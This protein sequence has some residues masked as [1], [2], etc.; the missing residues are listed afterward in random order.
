VRSIR[1]QRTTSAGN[2][3]E[4]AASSS[5]RASVGEELGGEGADAGEGAESVGKSGAVFQG[6]QGQLVAVEV[7]LAHV[8]RVS[9][10]ASV[11]D[12]GRPTAGDTDSLCEW[13]SGFSERQ[14]GL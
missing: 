6:V 14:S 7:L 12:S 2:S 1:E 8:W 13:I 9:V 3:R 11:A 4:A 10:S 5:R